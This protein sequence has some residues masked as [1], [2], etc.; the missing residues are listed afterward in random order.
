[1][2]NAP[3]SRLP[4]DVLITLTVLAGVVS[5]PPALFFALMGLSGG[6]FNLPVA[7]GVPALIAYPTALWLWVRSRR[8]PTTGRAWLL[9]IVGLL[10]ILVTS[11]L[12]VT[13]LGSAVIEGV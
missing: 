13:V 10:L 1:M 8:S 2:E 5:L 12:P 3:P 7:L 9:T 11:Y 6:F 4:S